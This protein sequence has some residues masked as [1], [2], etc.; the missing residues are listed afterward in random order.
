MMM[1]TQ[2]TLVLD[3][4]DAAAVDAAIRER[5]GHYVPDGESNREGA[6][7]AEICRGWLEM[8][9]KWGKLEDD[10]KSPSI[11]LYIE[12]HDDGG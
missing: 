8:L 12:G 1:G 7:I 6:L 5:G 2:L 10:K 9:G 4:L 3:D 11:G